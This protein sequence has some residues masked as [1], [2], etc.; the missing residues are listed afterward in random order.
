MTSPHVL[1]H[2][3]AGP[4]VC[5]GFGVHSGQRVRLTVRPAAVDAG[6]TFVRTDVT[7]R[8]NHILVTPEAVT[9]TQ[10]NTEISN[11]DGVSVSTI[12]HLMAALCALGVDNAV[13]EIDGPEVPIMDGS[14]LPFVQILDRAGRRALGKPRRYIEILRPVEIALGDKWACLSPGDGSG[15]EMSFEIA[16][17]SKAIGRQRVDYAVDETVFRTE[18]AAART[19]GF[20]QEVEMLRAAG[21]ARGGSLENAIVIDGDR[22][23]NPEGL[24]FEDEFVRH[25]AMDAVGDLYVL[26][27]PVIGRFEAVYGGHALNNLLVRALWARTDAWRYV[28]VSETLAEAV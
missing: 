7:D 9:R 21:L 28:T 22:V 2:T 1:Q 11:A 26:G 19:F 25:K 24:R 3:L 8:P 27:A 16:F 13:I 10:L 17:A 4:A 6:L 12:E 14:A 23:L 20:V 5:A 15:L 18:L